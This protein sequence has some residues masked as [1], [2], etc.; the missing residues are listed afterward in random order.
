MLIEEDCPLTNDAS[1][2]AVE[3]PT[4]SGLDVAGEVELTKSPKREDAEMIE[5]QCITGSEPS[6]PA[7]T[8]PDVPGKQCV[9]SLQ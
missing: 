9:N 1:S 7:T 5:I 4:S 6:A 2:P 3:S 8:A